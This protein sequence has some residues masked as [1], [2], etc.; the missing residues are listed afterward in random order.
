MKILKLGIRRNH[1]QVNT[2]CPIASSSFNQVNI[3]DIVSNV[4]YNN[5]NEINQDNQADVDL[6][7]SSTKV[8]INDQLEIKK[9]Q[10][11]IENLIDLSE[12]E[13]KLL[14]QK[15]LTIDN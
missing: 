3:S 10:A 11:K 2:P 4:N 13:N 7:I 14:I 1:E 5:Q 8:N 9:N 12:N 15:T 6:Q